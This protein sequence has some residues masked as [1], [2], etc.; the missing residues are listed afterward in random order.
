MAFQKWVYISRPGAVED[1]GHAMGEDVGGDVG[2]A[3]GGDVDLMML[4][5]IWRLLTNPNLS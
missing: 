2:Q 1:V 3:M 5:V 4:I